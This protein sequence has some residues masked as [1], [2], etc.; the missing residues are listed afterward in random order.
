M[1]KK[2]V[3]LK[4]HRCPIPA[5]RLRMMAARKEILPGD[6]VEVV[7][8]CPSFQ[9]DI[10]EFCEKDKKVLVETKKEGSVTKAKIKF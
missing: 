9:A 8:D 4:G 2:S 6:E 3:D 7:A 1:A 5:M 10:K